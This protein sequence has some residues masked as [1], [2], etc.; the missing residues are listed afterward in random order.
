MSW[1]FDDLMIG[2][3]GAPP[4]AS[5]CKLASH[6]FEAQG[7]QHVFY[8][9]ADGKLV[10][11]WWRG[12]QAPHWGYLTTPG[13]GAPL[14]AGDPASH[15][16]DAEGTQHVFYRAAD[17]EADGK[18]V[19]LWWKG[20]E[21]PHWGYLTTPGNSAPLAA[22]DPASHVFDAEGTQH[23]FYRSTGNQIIELW[24]SGGAAAQVSNLTE[25]S[26]RAPLAA[27]DPASHVFDAEGTQHVFYRAAAGEADSQIIE[28]WWRPGQQPQ[29]VKL[30]ERSGGPRAAGDPASHVFAAE[31]TQHVFYTSVDS[32]L[33]ELRWPGL[34]PSSRD[35]LSGH[36]GAESPD[37]KPASHVFPAKNMEH[38]F[39]IGADLH[40]RRIGIRGDQ[41][42]ALQDLVIASG[43]CPLAI[44]GPASHVF[45]TE[46]TQHVF[47][48]TSA[49]HIIELWS[50][51]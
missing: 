23:V 32:G 19:E 2:S 17:G 38:V 26:G 16:F 6:V 1:N 7:T 35:L 31:G 37:S 4:V 28:L 5:G 15:V 36:G 49:D 12:G 50:T 13:N 45:N 40:V 20:G 11:L 14:A 44:R 48:T 43:G 30:S 24:W 39:Y 10:E 8:R 25:R 51:E 27:G 3:G 42:P 18:L 41:T 9:A 33:I 21:T 29:F 46:G 22:S 47:Y 34:A